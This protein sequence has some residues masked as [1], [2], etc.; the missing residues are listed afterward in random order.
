MDAVTHASNTPNSRTSHL[1]QMNFRALISLPVI[2]LATRSEF[3]GILLGSPLS[4]K[5]LS[6]AMPLSSMYRPGW[7]QEIGWKKPE[8]R[9]NG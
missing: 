7:K 4:R 1:E 3:S 6:R 2:V 5:H 8:L 9:R